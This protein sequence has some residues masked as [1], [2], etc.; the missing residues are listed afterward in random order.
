MAEIIVGFILG[1][2]G[3]VF[4]ALLNHKL[5]EIK[6]QRNR[7]ETAG[8]AF[9]SAFTEHLMK[10]DESNS[11]EVSTTHNFIHKL[12]VDTYE[13]VNR[14]QIKFRHHLEHSELIEFNEAWKDY[15]G[16]ENKYSEE[17]KDYD[18]VPYD[19]DGFPQP[20][21]RDAT[22]RLALKRIE[23][24]LSFTKPRKL[25]WHI[26]TACMRRRGPCRS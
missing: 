1:I 12:L 17:F 10:L 9:K 21:L 3:T 18:L 15:C 11:F 7:F 19:T 16:K 2:L 20:Q 8:E 4:G 6:D 14:A 23:R 25:C 5:S 24:L 26:T 22:R 13:E